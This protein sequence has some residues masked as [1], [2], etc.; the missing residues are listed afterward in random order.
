MDNQEA[1]ELK[2][3]QTPWDDLPREELLRHIQR[4]Y[5]ALE[6]AR[7]MF[8]INAHGGSG[9]YWS[10]EGVPVEE[11][12]RRPSMLLNRREWARGRLPQLFS[13]ASQKRSSH[14]STKRR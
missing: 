9:R 6:S 13:G 3:G 10:S 12:L 5:S 14:A 11:Q 7:S 4:L 1:K 2:W 8:Q